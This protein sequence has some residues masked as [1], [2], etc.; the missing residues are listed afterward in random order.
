MKKS[1][2]KE[3]V[4][5]AAE[6]IKIINAYFGFD[7]NYYNLIPLVLNDKLFLL[8]NEDDF[9]FDG[10]S[11]Y[12]FKDLTKVKIKNDMCDKILKNEGLTTDITAP[13]INICDWKSVFESL[14]NIK[15]NIIVEKQTIN[16]KGAEFVIGRIEKIYKNFAYVWNFDAD[17]VWNHSPIRVPYSEITSI[18]FGSRYVDVFSKYLD[19]PPFNDLQLDQYNSTSE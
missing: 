6:N 3:L 17:G 10:Y 18:T 5:S 8:I 15:K 2:I 1:Q 16:D 12:R 14:K 11:I 4:K 7:T 9:I 19:E 13:D